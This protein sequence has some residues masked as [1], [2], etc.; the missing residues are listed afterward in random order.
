MDAQEFIQLI[1][2][3]K[4]TR[5][6]F[7]EE[8]PID[9]QALQLILEAAAYAPTAHNMQNFKIVVVDDK[10]LLLKL[11][12]LESKVTPT[13]IRENYALTSMTEGELRKRKTGFLANQFPASWLTPEARDGNVSQPASPLGGQIRRGP[14]LLFVLYDPATR[15]P[16]S[17]GDFL[18]IM[19]LGFMLEN[20]WLAA[21]AQEIG[22]QIISSLGNEPLASEIKTILDIP[23]SLRL[24][25]GCRLGYPSA[26]DKYRLR[27]RRDI[28]DFVSRNGYSF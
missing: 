6:P 9:P 20:I 8:R 24:V 12:R 14:V 5:A 27:V 11:S 17:E 3:R 15:A 16:A 18:G 10:E 28:E 23:P 22:F 1:K 4:T 19:S 13:F 21:A 26:E 7:D 25:F 2:D